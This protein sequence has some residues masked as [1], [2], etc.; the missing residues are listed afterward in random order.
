M[1]VTWKLWS[2]RAGWWAISAA[3]SPVAPLARQSWLIPKGLLW[4]RRRRMPSEHSADPALPCLR[5]AWVLSLLSITQVGKGNAKTRT[6]T[7][8]KLSS[9]LDM[10]QAFKNKLPS[11]T[12]ENLKH[13][14]PCSLLLKTSPDFFSF[15]NIT[16][17]SCLLGRL[18]CFSGTK[19][20][21][22][23]GSFPLNLF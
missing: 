16:L 9:S 4:G 5:P 18:E 11:Q 14:F 7:N 20:S 12:F 8:W 17:Y 23:T 10:M 15:T 2:E 13:Q 3:H 6:E 19:I 1:N 21:I 22:S